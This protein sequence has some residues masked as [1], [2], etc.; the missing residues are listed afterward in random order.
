MFTARN[1]KRLA[2]KAQKKEEKKNRRPEQPIETTTITRD[3]I[4]LGGVAFFGSGPRKPWV[5]GPGDATA[6]ILDE[7][8]R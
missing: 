5:P 2:I 6:I 8:M 7:L 3:Q 1:A 4:D